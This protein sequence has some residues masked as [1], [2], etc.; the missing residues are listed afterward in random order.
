MGFFFVSFC[1]IGTSVL[2]KKEIVLSNAIV[3]TE[4]F[5]DGEVSLWMCCNFNWS[6][7]FYFWVGL[8]YSIFEHKALDGRILLDLHCERIKKMHQ[9]AIVWHC[10]RFPNGNALV[11]H[12]VLILINQF[13]SFTMCANSHVFRSFSIFYVQS[14]VDWFWIKKENNSRIEMTCKCA[15]FS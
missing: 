2:N 13:F 3:F 14:V 6:R 4:M 5:E 1:W 8:L 7:L 11:F 9:N 10:T 12:I 15:W